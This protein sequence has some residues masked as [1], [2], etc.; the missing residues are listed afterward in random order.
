MSKIIFRYGA[1]GS[2]KSAH[3]LTTG[4]NFEERSISVTYAKPIVDTRSGATIT[5]RA[6]IA[7]KGCLLIPENVDLTVFFSSI[8]EKSVLIIDEC[9]FM[10][11]AGVDELNLLS[12]EKDLLVVCYGLRTDSESRL[13]EGAKRLLEIAD[14]I[15]EIKS[16]CSRCY[17]KAT[18]N[19]YLGVKSDVVFIGDSDYLPLCRECYF[20]AKG[21]DI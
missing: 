3:L 12:I 21:E 6:G 11:P 9:Q 5:T 8:D 1:M 20:K 7:P 15:E 19:L 14:V 17:R 18:M 4:H 13:F 10:S 2:S 16:C